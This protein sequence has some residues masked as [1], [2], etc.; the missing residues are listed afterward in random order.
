ME[1]VDQLKVWMPRTVYSAE[2]EPIICLVNPTDSLKT[3][4]KGAVIGSAYEVI[5]FQEEE[6]R[7]DVSCSYIGSNISLVNQEVHGEL[8]TCCSLEQ[9]QAE[10]LTQQN[11]PEHLKQLYPGQGIQDFHRKYVLV[12]ADKAANNVVV[13]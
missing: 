12:P 2:T 11:I 4:K 8:R 3:L 6:M 10:E 9:E 5:A 1:S 13:V 7:S